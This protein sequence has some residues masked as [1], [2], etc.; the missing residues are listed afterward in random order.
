[1]AI[2]EHKKAI[3]IDPANSN[4][5]YGMALIYEN[6]GNKT[7]AIRYWEEF[8]KL[9]EPLQSMVEQGAGK[10]GKVKEK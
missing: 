3:E 5:F 8:V 4:A 9:T 1:M 6:R 2:Q 7:E 10:V